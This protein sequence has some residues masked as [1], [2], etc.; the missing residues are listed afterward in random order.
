MVFFIKTVALI[1]T[2]VSQKTFRVEEIRMRANLLGF[3]F[4]ES[5][6]ALLFDQLE[7]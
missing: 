4:K 6:P 2:M 3:Q 1:R 7:V 5:S